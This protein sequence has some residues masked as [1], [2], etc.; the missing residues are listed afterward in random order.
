[1]KTTK[2][3]LIILC[4]YFAI[5]ASRDASRDGPDFTWVR[6]DNNT[7]YQIIECGAEVTLS[8]LPFDHPRGVLVEENKTCHLSWVRD[9]DPINERNDSVLS[10]ER[11]FEFEPVLKKLTCKRFIFFIPSPPEV[12]TDFLVACIPDKPM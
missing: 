12:I 3:S 6:H 11:N 4:A 8:F 7:R 10:N 2:T 1:M 9:S 5:A